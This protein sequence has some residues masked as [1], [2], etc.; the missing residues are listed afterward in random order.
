MENQTETQTQTNEEWSLEEIKRRR[1]SAYSN[2]LT[3]SD[4]LFIESMRMKEMGMPGWEE[5]KQ[6]GVDR[7][8]QIQAE[9]PYPS[10]T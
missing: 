2:P 1:Q 5:I 10:N 8:F 6:K 4:I 3:G 7:Y 9:H